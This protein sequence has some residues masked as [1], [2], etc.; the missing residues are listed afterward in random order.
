MSE[1]EAWV[2]LRA[3]FAGN[4]AAS[5]AWSQTAPDIKGK[6]IEYV[7]AAGSDED[8]RSRAGE[9]ERLA[10]AGPIQ[11]LGVG[12]PGTPDHLRHGFGGLLH[13]PGSG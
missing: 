8:R 10:A 9:V 13:P 3:A 1:D 2:A 7:A 4:D 12:L 11:E 6:C 5:A